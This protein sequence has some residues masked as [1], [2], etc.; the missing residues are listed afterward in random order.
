[1][2]PRLSSETTPVENLRTDTELKRN[3]LIIGT[4]PVDLLLAC[5]LRLIGV[6]RLVTKRNGR[7]VAIPRAVSIDDESMRTIQSIGNLVKAENV[8]TRGADF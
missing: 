2:Q 5:F 6:P 1:M 4:G 8:L 7:I 3:D